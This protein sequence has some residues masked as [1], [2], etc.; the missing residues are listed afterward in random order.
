MPTPSTDVHALGILLCEMLTGSTAPEEVGAT[1]DPELQEV[2]YACTNGDYAATPSA[3]GVAYRLRELALRRGPDLGTGLMPT[4]G[5]RSRLRASS[6]RLP[7]VYRPEPPVPALRSRDPYDGGPRRRRGSTGVALAAGGAVL[8]V[9]IG[10]AAVISLQATPVPPGAPQTSPDLPSVGAPTPPA[11]ATAA[12]QEGGTA[13][14]Q[15]WFAALT[16]AVRTGETE[17]FRETISPEC[18]DCQ[19]VLEAIE[20]AHADGGSMRG[21]AYVV[22]RV[23]TT[24][25]LFSVDRTLY[26]AVVDRSERAAVGA[27]GESQA[28]LPGISFT[29]CSL[30]LQWADGRWLVREVVTP[31]CVE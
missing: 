24:A 28:T 15:Y 30:V 31:G 10:I 25:D 11:A 22:R 6:E 16:H 18:T 8:A 17:P 1:I 2:I 3:A 26:V 19:Q 21:G 5:R 23:T 27:G 13:F 12:S 20:A 7:E 29:S 9:A 4:P 14:V